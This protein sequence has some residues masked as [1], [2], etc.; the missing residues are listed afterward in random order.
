MPDKYPMHHP[1]AGV[2]S[3]YVTE[4][5]FE[6]AWEPKGWVKGPAHG[7]ADAPIEVVPPAAPKGDAPKPSVTAPRPGGAAGEPKES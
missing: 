6:K 3:T 7:S 2:E 5:Q 4:R 1:K